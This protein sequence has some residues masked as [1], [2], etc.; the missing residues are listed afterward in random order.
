[1][2]VQYKICDVVTLNFSRVFV[3]CI[4]IVFFYAFLVFMVFTVMVV[5]LVFLAYFIIHFCR[6]SVEMVFVL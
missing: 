2:V 1:M 4:D 6:L 3:I 5:F